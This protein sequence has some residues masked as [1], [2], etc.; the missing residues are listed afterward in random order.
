MQIDAFVF[1]VLQHLFVH[2][3]LDWRPYAENEHALRRACKKLI[4]QKIATTIITKMG[5]KCCF[6]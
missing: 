1:R 4:L 5:A 2:T 3:I 6:L